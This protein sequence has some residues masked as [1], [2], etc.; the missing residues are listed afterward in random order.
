MELIWL[1][2]LLGVLLLVLRP[3]RENAKARTAYVTAS[4]LLECGAAVRTALGPGFSLTL[5][6]LADN[7]LIAV[8]VDSL[9]RVFLV[10]GAAI[11]LLAGVFAFGYL[12][13]DKR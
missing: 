13:D 1:P 2:F 11:W 12:R 8:K 6:H 5:G 10:M 9:S 7:L 3:L 4:L